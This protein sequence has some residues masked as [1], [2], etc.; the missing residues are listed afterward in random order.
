MILESEPTIYD[1]FIYNE[2]ITQQSLAEELEPLIEHLPMIQSRIGELENQNLY[3]LIKI[4]NEII[5]KNDTVLNSTWHS[6]LMVSRTG[7]HFK[8]INNIQVPLKVVESEYKEGVSLVHIDQNINTNIKNKYNDDFLM[9]WNMTPCVKL[10]DIIKLNNNED[11]VEIH[12]SNLS[13]NSTSTISFPS[14]TKSSK[15]TNNITVMNE[16]RHIIGPKLLNMLTS[17]GWPTV[18]NPAQKKYT[19]AN[20]INS[21]FSLVE[22]NSCSNHNPY[23]FN[24]PMYIIN[25]LFII[26]FI[27]HYTY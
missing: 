5:E 22:S 1:S 17:I 19:V 14:S 8:G 9:G 13:L 24:L 3:E 27:F 15:N 16:T 23:S 21:I 6:Y 4:F 18:E 20:S 10:E 11:F 25:I 12:N 7:L 2:Y 26:L